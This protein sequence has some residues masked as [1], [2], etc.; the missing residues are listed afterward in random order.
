MTKSSLPPFHYSLR[1]TGEK[2][3]ILDILRRRYVKL[4]PEEWVRQHF[5]NYLITN[6]GYPR[7]YLANEVEILVG[8]K[9]LRCD[10]ILYDKSLQPLA[11]IEYKAP[12]VKLDEKVFQQVTSYNS[13]L[14]VRYLFLSNGEHH[15]V[16]EADYERHEYTLL[17]DI[18]D[19]AS[20]SQETF[21]HG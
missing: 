11:I 14:H 2:Y 7:A 3:Y 17:P 21:C 9:K 19:Y 12:H 4:T 13:L 16:C 8:E 10:T 1:K 5:V 6:K 20:L 18:P 15:I